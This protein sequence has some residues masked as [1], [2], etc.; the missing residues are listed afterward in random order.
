[1]AELEVPKVVLRGPVDGD[2]IILPMGGLVLQAPS[3]LKRAG[4]ET[5]P[6]DEDR[7]RAKQR[8]WKG[9]RQVSD[10][11][12]WGHRRPCRHD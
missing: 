3:L 1:M 6:C 10:K 11:N 8:G 7:Q 5:T 4:A 12:R 9:R 2:T